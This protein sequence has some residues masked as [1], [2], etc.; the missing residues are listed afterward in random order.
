LNELSKSACRSPERG[1]TSPVLPVGSYADSHIREATRLPDESRAD[2]DAGTRKQRGRLRVPG[3]AAR[4]TSWLLARLTLGG[5]S[6]PREDLRLCTAIDGGVEPWLFGRG[7]HG[8]LDVFRSERFQKEISPKRED[9][10]HDDR[11]P[12]CQSLCYANRQIGGTPCPT[13]ASQIRQPA[14]ADT[15]RRMVR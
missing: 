6:H 1:R 12:T 15:R 4:A 14:G 5:P 8:S 9:R 3:A 10:Q 11:S 13:A 7:L 2:V